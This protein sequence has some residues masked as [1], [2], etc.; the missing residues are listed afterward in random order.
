MSYVVSSAFIANQ[1]YKDVLAQV[2]DNKGTAQ[3]TC[4]MY[5]F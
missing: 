5:T 3:C 2:E 4:I 1:M